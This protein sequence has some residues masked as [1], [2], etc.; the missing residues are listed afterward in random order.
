MA[1]P[2]SRAIKKGERERK[3]KEEAGDGMG[4]EG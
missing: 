3:K 2:G 1:A 4:W